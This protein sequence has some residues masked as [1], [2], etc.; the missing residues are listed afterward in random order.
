M[1]DLKTPALRAAS[2]SSIPSGMTLRKIVVPE[3]KTRPAGSL[4]DPRSATISFVFPGGTGGLPEQGLDPL[5]K[6][7][8]GD[9]GCS[10]GR[11]QP[12]NQHA[13]GPRIQIGVRAIRLEK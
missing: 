13:S 8:Q 6:N 5:P 7:A 10:D 4:N 11:Q 1:R 9:P 2:K 3:S 12:L